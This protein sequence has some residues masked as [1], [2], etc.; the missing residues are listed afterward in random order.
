[1]RKIWA[2]RASGLWT[3]FK[4]SR[5]KLKN[6]EVFP[7]LIEV[8]VEILASLSVL[9]WY[10][11]I[12]HIMHTVTLKKYFL[13]ARGRIL[14]RNWVISPCSSQ[15]L[16]QQILLP[17]PP[18][19]K[20]WNWFCNVNIVYGNLKSEISQETSTKLYVHEFGFSTICVAPPIFSWRFPLTL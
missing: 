2:V 6:R 10:F 14:G 18:W 17:P 9:L 13:L 19:A 12:L 11:R 20:V 15:T 4:N 7:Y 16:Y 1:M 5:L 8:E 3:P